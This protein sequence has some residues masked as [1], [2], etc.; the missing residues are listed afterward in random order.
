MVTI[1]QTVDF[2]VKQTEEAIHRIIKEVYAEE[3]NKAKEPQGLSGWIM[4]KKF[5]VEDWNSIQDVLEA[6][7][8][9]YTNL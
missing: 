4:I 8:L 9:G 7:K 2:A 3:I 1:N 6:I 5:K